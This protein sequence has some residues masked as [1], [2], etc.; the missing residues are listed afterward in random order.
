MQLYPDLFERVRT[1]KNAVV[2]LDVKLGVTPII[3]SPRRVPDALRDLLKKELDRM[4]SMRVIRILDINE[5]SNWVH[6]LVPVVKPNGK[7]HVCLDPHTLNSVLQHNIHNAQRFIDIIT[8]IGGFTHCSMIDANSGFWT[9]PLNAISQLLTTFDTPWGCYCFLK[10]QFG[11]WESQY[12]FQFCMDF[13]NFKAINKGTHIITDDMLIVGSDSSSTGSHDYHLIQVLN[14]CCEIGLK[15]NPDKCIMKSM[16]VLFFRHLVTS[17]RL[18]PDLRKINAIANMPAPQ[19]KTQLQS[20]VGLC[21]YLTCYIPHLTDVLSPLRAL[22][23]KSIEFEWGQLHNEAF[24]KA[25]QAIVNSCTLQYFNSDDPITIQV[26]TSTIG[27]SA[28]LMQQGEVISYHS[29]ALTPTQQHYSNIERECYGFM[30]RVE[31][32]HHYVF[33]HEFTVQTDHQPLVQL[34][35]KPLCEISPRLQ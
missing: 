17:D 33:G 15:L 11:L 34:M 31:H 9:L 2:H 27:V 16:Q 32:F 1:I 4:E 28:A 20:F 21:N 5:A 26:D 6:A 3:C 22:I 19:N 10:L 29:R 13:N 25:G 14:K 23:V 24:K 30:N 18:K 8:Q 35:T 7:L 12:F